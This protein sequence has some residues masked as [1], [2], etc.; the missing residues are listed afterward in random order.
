[1]NFHERHH[2]TFLKSVSWFFVGFTVS[3]LVLLY[4][5]DDHYMI[6]LIEASAI[7]AFKFVFFYI[8]ERIWN[9]TDFGQEIKQEVSK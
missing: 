9:K 1:M 4:F 6:S 3:F 5:N 8:H 7:Q 2:R